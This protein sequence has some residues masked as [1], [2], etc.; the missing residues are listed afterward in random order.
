[1][2][3]K[4]KIPYIFLSLFAICIVLYITSLNTQSAL[5]LNRTVCRFVRSSLAAVTSL[6]PFSVFEALIILSPVF[7][8]F[9]FR[10]IFRSSVC[11]MKKRFVAV[12]SLLS[13]FPSF[14]ILTLGISYRAPSPVQLKNG[15]VTEDELISSAEYLASSISEIS[16]YISEAPSMPELRDELSRSY[17]SNLADYGY[18]CQKFPL[19][20]KAL[21]S[22]ALSYMG[23][24]A[25]YSFPTGEVN[26]NTEI[27][28]YTVPFT[29][30][31]EYA[32][33]MGIASERDANFFAFVACVNSKSQYVKYSGLMSGL[34]YLLSDIYKTDRD[35]YFSILSTLPARA[36]S[37]ID[38]YKQYSVKYKDSFIFHASDKL[39]SAHLDLWDECGK[40]S[41]S[42]VTRCIVDYLNKSGSLRIKCS[43]T[44]VFRS[45]KWDDLLYTGA[46]L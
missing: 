7:L 6:F 16:D 36:T 46:K 32:H 1:M 10:Y 34:E 2:K 11:N 41:Y 21:F 15:E 23:T 24:L 13:L 43:E 4:R 31:H 20:K 12:L 18:N 22:R 3:L 14:Y 28:K 8:V 29:V 42:L 26:I 9:I 39:N 5:F 40:H 45:E 19:P 44:T 33:F 25:L 35:S 17:S 27:P 37:D 30:A 38:L